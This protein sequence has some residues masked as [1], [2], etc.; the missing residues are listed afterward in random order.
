MRG[1]L[2]SIQRYLKKQNYGFTIFTDAEFKTTL[3]TL[4]AKQMDLKAKGFG[5]KSKTSDGLKDKEIEKLDA[6]KCLGIESPQA[7]INTAVTCKIF[8]NT[9]RD[10]SYLRA[11]M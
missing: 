2:S 6:S 1:F 7:V 5:N 11:A 3:A 8:F 10:I 9:R 4:K